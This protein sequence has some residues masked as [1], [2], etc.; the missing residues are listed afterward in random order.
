MRVLTVLVFML[1]AHIVD[2]Y[3]LQQ[4]ILAKLK[5]KSWWQE[6]EPNKMY[7]YDYIVALAIHAFSWSV[8]ISLPIFI[9]D[10]FEPTWLVYLFL[11]YN[12][13]IHAVIDNAKANLRKINLITDQCL[14]FAQILMTWVFWFLLRG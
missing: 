2:D 8:M 13:V 14:H 4:G 10:N 5:Q 1:F 9:A 3:Y 6:N 12:A 7:R 11:V